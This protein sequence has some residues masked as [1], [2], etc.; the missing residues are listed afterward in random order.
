V[1]YF[2]GVYEDKLNNISNQIST[3][4]EGLIYAIAIYI[5]I[6]YSVKYTLFSRLTLGYF[7]VLAFVFQIISRYFLNYIKIRNYK[8]GVGLIN[9]LIIGDIQGNTET[10]LNEID[11]E[12]KYGLNIIGVLSDTIV[13]NNYFKYI[14]NTKDI[15]EI[16]NKYNIKSIIITSKVNGIDE[17]IEFCLLK[18]ISIYTFG[19]AINLMN[20]PVEIVFMRDIPVLKIKEILIS[21]ASAKLKRLMDLLI[22]FALIIIL[23]PLFILI[24]ILIK[25]TS[26]GSIFFKHKRLGLNGKLIDVY[27]FRTMVVNAQE[28]LERILSEDPNLK[29][30]FEETYKLKN[31]PRLTKMGKILRK[32][33]L[34]ELPQ[35]FNV[36]KGDMSLVGPRSIVLEEINLYKEHAKYLLRV[37]PGVMGLC[38][39]SGRND[40][41][42]EERIKMDMQYIMNWNLWLDINILLKTIPAVLKKDGAY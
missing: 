11:E 41:D 20:Y 10:L 12:H 14:G 32:T 42:Y 25:I 5:I 9:T 30:E 18:Y 39:V 8:K 7:I 26:P 27:K 31:D 19:N 33:S 16:I 36:L 28:V 23:F 40:V 3:I 35:I 38:Q 1:L 22:S 6:S 24:A 4:F 2:K 17:I 15:K 21:G 37:L 13:N 34:D 29:K